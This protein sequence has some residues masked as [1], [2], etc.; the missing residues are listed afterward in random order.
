M[1]H[2]AWNR[3]G[4]LIVSVVAALAWSAARLA[5]P[6]LTAAAVDNGIVPSDGD[7]TLYYAILIVL[8]GLVQLAGTGFRRYGAFWLAYRTETD[9]RA[10]LF[11]HFQRLH[12]AFHDEA[13]A[14]DLMALANTDL[15]QITQAMVA[16]PITFASMLTLL[17]VA[18]IMLFQSWQLTLLALGALPLLLVAAARFSSRVGPVM[19]HLQNRLGNLSSVVEESVAGIR[20]IKGFGSEETQIRTLD[21]A[22][23]RVFD[24]AIGA[25]RLRSRFL[26][27]VD[28]I[29]TL[30]FVAVLWYGGRLVI[31][32]QIAVGD[33]IAYNLYIAMLIQP[34]R[35]AGQNVAQASRAVASAGRIDR[36]LQSEPAIFDPP[37]PRGLPADG[38]GEVHFERVKFRYGTGP[39]ILDDLELVLRGGES[40]AI[41]GATGS[42]KTTSARLI[43]RLYDAEAG[44]V[45]IDGVDVRLLRLN[46]LRR[47]VGIVFEET[48]LFTSTVR[49]NIAFSDPGASIDDIRKAARLAGAEEFIDALPDGFDTEIGEHGYSLSGGQRQRIAIARAVI[50]DPR[51]LILDDATS[52]VDPTKEHEIRAALQ[53]VMHGRTTLIIAHRPATIALADRVVLLDRGRIVADGTHAGLLATSA[54]YREVLAQATARASHGPGA[55]LATAEDER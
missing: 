55:D 6:L 17:G 35:I 3:K 30:A 22:N 18:V 46:D 34:M 50:A 5:V 37:H 16:G 27:I 48:F 26:P 32:G 36:A 40:V 42:G 24:Q 52:S 1:L 33:L 41:V 49:E 43:S 28:F 19:L 15:L 45:S 21:D 12:F 47:S 39:L 23:S 11:M 9:L 51:V 8:V 4:W 31:D 44:Q 20:V 13:Q 7:K 53:E 10:R 38:A 14:G 29:P 2:M 54:R 25:A